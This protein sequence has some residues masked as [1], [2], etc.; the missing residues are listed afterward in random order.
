MPTVTGFQ[1]EMELFSVTPTD[2]S[3]C[4]RFSLAEH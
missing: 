1:K 4:L 2:S 3:L